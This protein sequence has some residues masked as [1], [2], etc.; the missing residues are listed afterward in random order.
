[1]GCNKDDGDCRPCLDC[2]DVV[3]PIVPRCQDVVLAAGVYT[4]A[5]VTVN[6]LGCI[7]SLAS[8]EPLLYS[9]DPCCQTAGGSGGSSGAG[10]KGDRGEAGK[11][12]T[13]AIGTVTSVS[14]DAQPKVT[15]VGTET[16]AVLNFEIPRGKAGE[17]AENQVGI[18]LDEKGMVVKKGIITEVPLGW[19]GYSNLIGG[20]ANGLTVNIETNNEI[21]SATFTV[22]PA[23]FKAEMLAEIKKVSDAL[24]VADNR[25]R[26]LE[27]KVATL[28]GRVR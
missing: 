7:V 3:P 21:G 18:N 23:D 11:N 20:S 2:P 24:A 8:G 17:Q 26:T 15:N 27:T 5:T 16:N 19:P 12:A 6:E 13:I 14:A 4:N 25:I 1:M 22:D 9:P 10:L 28:E